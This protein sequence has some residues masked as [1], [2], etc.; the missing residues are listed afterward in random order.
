MSDGT[1]S[2]NPGAGVLIDT[3][4]LTVGSDTVNRQ[5]VR[6][7]GA[8]AAEVAEVKNAAPQMDAYGQ[9]VRLPGPDGQTFGAVVTPE[10]GTIYVSGKT[11][12]EV[13]NIVYQSTVTAATGVTLMAGVVNTKFYVLQMTITTDTLTT[14]Y[15]RTG[16]VAGGVKYLVRLPA[17]QTVVI[18]A[19]MGTV[20]C[21]MESGQAFFLDCTVSCTA[22][23]SV[24]Y[25]Q[26]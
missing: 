19:P 26:V 4:S 2:I 24:L 8:A 9:V 1:V 6:L 17:S 12:A 20:L 25:A 5:R 13:G 11:R 10:I 15:F 23:L 3:D 18:A 21:S 22:W 16:S 7:A 14:L